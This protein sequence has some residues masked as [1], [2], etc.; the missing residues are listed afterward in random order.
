MRAV[1]VP[2]AQYRAG[3]RSRAASRSGDQRR[4]ERG[5]GERHIGARLSYQPLENV[6]R[7]IV[8]SSLARQLAS[9]PA[10]Q[11]AGSPARRRLVCDIS[12]KP[13]ATNEW[14]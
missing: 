9:S 1:D 5:R 4:Q 11:L 2:Q 12:G 7:S 8:A 6:G 13:P 3:R 14:E 10:R